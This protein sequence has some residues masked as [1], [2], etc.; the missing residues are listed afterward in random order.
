MIFP[1]QSAN[2]KKSAFGEAKKNDIPL[3][4]RK[5]AWYSIWSFYAVYP[6]KT[7]RITPLK[8]LVIVKERR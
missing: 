7:Y 8:Y 6:Y 3:F 4:E 1:L 2:L 5:I